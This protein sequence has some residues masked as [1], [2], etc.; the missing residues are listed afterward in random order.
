MEGQQLRNAAVVRLVAVDLGGRAGAGRRTVQ[1]GAQAAV[2]QTDQQ[3]ENL[4][5]A[6][7]PHSLIKGR[8]SPDLRVE[9]TNILHLPALLLSV[10]TMKRTFPQFIW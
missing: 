9:I 5:A 7:D 1:Q 3:K 4:P 10:E 6:A 8:C 2:E